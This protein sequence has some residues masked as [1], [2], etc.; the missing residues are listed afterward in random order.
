MI[1]GTRARLRRQKLGVDDLG[2]LV[3]L[4]SDPKAYKAKLEELN[5]VLEEIRQ[6][7]EV[8]DTVE[9]AEALKARAV[10]MRAEAEAELTESR[11]LA[12]KTRANLTTEAR[13]AH[14]ERER[15]L[16]ARE[17]TLSAEREAF[18]AQKRKQ[19]AKDKTK[20][21]ELKDREAAVERDESAL[22]VGKKTLDA[23]QARLDAEQAELDAEKAVIARQKQAAEQFASQL[24]GN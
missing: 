24:S 20:A 7:T 17:E 8:A 9:K 6:L 4:L 18:N 15:V 14:I 2:A 22:K 23:A 13:N 11:E 19:A 16:D 12:I 1:T 3:A 5:G 21:K 10:D